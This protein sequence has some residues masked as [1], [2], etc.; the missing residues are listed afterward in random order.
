M[1]LRSVRLD[2]RPLTT[3]HR[4]AALALWRQPGVRRYLWDDRIITPE[5]ALAPLRVSEH[6]FREHRFGLWGLHQSG[7][8]ALLGFCGL[9]VA[10]VMAEPELLFALDDGCCGRGYA[11]EA[12]RAVLQ[13]AFDELGLP[14][15]GA[16]TD[17]ANLRSSR[18][19]EKLGM[20]LTRRADH[21]GLDTLFYGCTIDDWASGIEA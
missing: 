6:D 17:A 18:L 20:R 2:L 4:D 7:D 13:H 8:P 10:D 3:A 9:R 15:V 12:A 5:Q 11:W 16:A 21:N 1:D 19:L 14:A